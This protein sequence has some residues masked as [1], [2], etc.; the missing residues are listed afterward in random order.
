MK[1]PLWLQF[2]KRVSSP[3]GNGAKAGARKTKNGES[4][5]R[6]RI[7]LILAVLVAMDAVALFLFFRPP[8]RSVAERQADFD[9]S[10][11]R[12]E[13][14]LATVRQMRDIQTKLQSAIQND[15]KFAKDHFLNRKTAFS[16]MLTDLEKQASKDQLKT[17]TIGY[18]LKEDTDHPGYV[19]VEVSMAVEGGYPDLVHFINRL[20]QSDLFWIIETLNVSGGGA[21]RGLRLSVKMGTYAVTS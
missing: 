19:K 4:K 3:A 8:S 17:S 20:E 7:V 14:T 9:Q 15:R 5:V 12:Y 18:E 13:Q 10:R 21:G 16:A 2:G 6:S 11:T 1:L